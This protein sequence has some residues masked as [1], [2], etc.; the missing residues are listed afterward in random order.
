VKTTAFG[1]KEPDGRRA[2]FWL[3]PI[4]KYGWQWVHK[5]WLM[6]PVAGVVE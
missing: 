6:P 5:G 2:V 1:K 4:G 3:M